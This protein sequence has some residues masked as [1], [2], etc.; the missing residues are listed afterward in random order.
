MPVWGVVAAS[1]HSGLM[2]G[3]IRICRL[4]FGW[5]PGAGLHQERG[6]ILTGYYRSYFG[7]RMS[8]YIGELYSRVSDCSTRSAAD[9]RCPDVQMIG[10]CWLVGGMRVVGGT[11]AARCT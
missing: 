9:R 4:T 11:T 2:R 10:H 8:Q 1:A 3:V 5:K 7:G 6:M